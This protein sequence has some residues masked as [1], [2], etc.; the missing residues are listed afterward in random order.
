MLLDGKQYL[1][2]WDGKAS[3]LSACK[4]WPIRIQSAWPSRPSIDIQVPFGAA[5]ECFPEAQR[6][7][8][9]Q[10]QASRQP[11]RQRHRNCQRFTIG[12]WVNVL[13]LI[14][15]T[16]DQVRGEWS[17]KG[18]ESKSAGGYLPRISLPVIVDG[19]YDFEVDFTRALPVLATLPHCF[20][21]R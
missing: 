17:W 14:D 16:R 4:D 12:Q 19:N 3:S 6:W 7:I 11:R 21:L 20:R 8:P 10:M 13:R 18:A 9:K 2:H 15:I 1:P 5:Y